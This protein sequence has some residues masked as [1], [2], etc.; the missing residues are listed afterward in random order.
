MAI[1][2]AAVS[3][4]LPQDILMDIFALLEIPDLVRA[5]SLSLLALQLAGESVAC[6][7]SLAEKRVYKLTL[8]DPPIRSRLLIG[9]CQGLLVTVDERSEMQIVNPVTG[10]Q[11]DVPS[12]ITI[13]QVKPIYDDSDAIAEYLYSRHTA[14]ELSFARV[15]DDSRWTWLPPRLHYEDCVYKDGQLYAVNYDG[16]ID[17][18]DLSGP[19]V[20][21]KKVLGMTDA[22]TYSCMYIVQAPWGGLLQVW[23]S[24]ED[25]E[26]EPEPGEIVFWNTGK[27]EIYEI[28]TAGGKQYPALKANH[29]YF[30]DDSYFWTIGYENNGRDMGILSLNNGIKEEL[31]SPQLW[32]DFPAPVWITLNLRM[33]NSALNK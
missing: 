1:V 22:I 24:Y 10:E 4:E 20:P 12:V 2:T 15:G 21:M 16:E 8:P 30:T 33:M 23:R 18:Y 9:S 32:S 25:Y 27:F 7:Y 29:A 26:L 17:V 11:V 5:G 19:A 14:K 3:P 31:V 6:L 13:E 28:D